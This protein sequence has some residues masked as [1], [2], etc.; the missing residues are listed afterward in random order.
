[1]KLL[2][3]NNVDKGLFVWAIGLLKQVLERQGRYLWLLR[4]NALCENICFEFYS[5]AGS[6]ENRGNNHDEEMFVL[7]TGLLKQVLQ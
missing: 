7:A 4:N 2:N 5:L 1:M 6:A 3:W